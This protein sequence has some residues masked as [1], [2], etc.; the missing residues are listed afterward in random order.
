MSFRLGFRVD[1]VE[2][3]TAAFAR[4]EAGLLE[5]IPKMLDAMGK[6]VVGIARDEYL[7]GPRPDKLGRVTGNLASMTTSEVNGNEV[8]IGNNL[9][10]GGIWERG[11]TI[12]AHDIY[13]KTGRFLVFEFHG[14]TVFATKVHKK[15]RKVDARPYLAPALRDSEQAIR[16][17]AQFFADDAVQ[18][19]FA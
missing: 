6:H 12:P 7:S 4:L 8:S 17:I 18:E 1:G 16:D 14:R 2:E 9:P 11:G 13:P 5:R 10:Y 3:G 15:A 19:A